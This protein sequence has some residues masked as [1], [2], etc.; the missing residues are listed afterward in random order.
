MIAQDLHEQQIKFQNLN[1]WW[2]LIQNK[3]QQLGM[4]QT[5][6]ECEKHR[7][8]TEMYTTK[9]D[10]ILKEITRLNELLGELS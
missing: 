7:K 10:E 9:H 6:K 2:I 8:N 5:A 4:K 1:N 3:F